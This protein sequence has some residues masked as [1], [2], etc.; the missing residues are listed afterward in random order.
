MPGL[1]FCPC[2]QGIKRPSGR[3]RLKSQSE[4][5]RKAANLNDFRQELFEEREGR[6]KH[7]WY[8]FVS[9]HDGLDARASCGM[10]MASLRCDVAEKFWGSK[11]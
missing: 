1:A 2:S 4:S 8:Q 10:L 11:R 3:K 9:L 6:H 7:V 5:G